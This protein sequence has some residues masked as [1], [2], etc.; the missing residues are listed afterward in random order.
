MQLRLIPDSPS[1]QR[2]NPI[3]SWDCAKC[4]GVDIAAQLAAGESLIVVRSHLLTDTN[5]HSTPER[6]LRHGF[7]QD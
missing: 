2:G 3:E 5:R 1:S 4:M 6:A 7:Q